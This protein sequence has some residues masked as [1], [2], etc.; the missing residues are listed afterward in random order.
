MLL[1]FGFKIDKKR[2]D[3]VRIPRNES[4]VRRTDKNVNYRHNF[5]FDQI[6]QRTNFERSLRKFGEKIFRSLYSNF[7][8]RPD[9]ARKTRKISGRRQIRAKVA[10]N[11]ALFYLHESFVQSNLFSFANIS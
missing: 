2:S 7:N 9:V 5:I 3:F 6:K 11:F 4:L 8:H 10:D 1:R